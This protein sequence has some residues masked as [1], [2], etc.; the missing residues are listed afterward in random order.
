MTI[1]SRLAGLF[2]LPLLPDEE[3]ARQAH[4]LRVIAFSAI[5][6][7]LLMAVAVTFFMSDPLESL[8]EIGVLFVWE[9][10]IVFLVERGQVRLAS[11]I[12]TLGLVVIIFATSYLYGGVRQIAFSNY[13]IAILT[14][15]MLL[16]RRV[17]MILAA[18]GVV[19]GA[20]LLYAEVNRALPAADPLDSSTTWAAASA[21]FVWAAVVLYIALTSIND[22]LARRAEEVRKRREAQAEAEKHL[23]HN[24]RL[25][26]EL[27]SSSAELTRAYDTTIDGWARALELRDGE[28]EG[29]SRRVTNAAV[30]L[31][32]ALGVPEPELGH[33]RRGALLHDIGKMGI[34][35]AILLKPGP[36]TDNEWQTMRKHPEHAYRLLSPI[37]YLRPALDIPYAHHEKWDGTGYPRGLK[38]EEIPLAARIFAVVDV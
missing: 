30:S 36:L 33:L 38:G 13:V 10:T 35:D 20:L 12:L 21:T 15:G 31:A 1:R 4:I 19:G 16:G 8:T 18:A 7:S 14:G 9:L 6:L 32:R 2:S 23:R 17:A 27:Q 11:L 24:V 5:A 26:E 34:P 28:T 29:H 25:F 37:A 3:R 22:E